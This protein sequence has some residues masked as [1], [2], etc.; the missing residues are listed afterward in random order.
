[1]RDAGGDGDRGPAARDE[2]PDRDE[3]T[4]TLVELPL[5][6]GDPTACLFA[7]QHPAA[8]T[9]VMTD[10]VADVVTC[11]CSQRCR[12]YDERHGEVTSGCNDTGRDDGCLARHQRQDRVDEGEHHKDDV[13]PAGGLS[14]EVSELVE[15]RCASACHH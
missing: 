2:P 4:A 11:E 6:P 14:N 5:G 7:A 9:E 1:M 8:R 3:L 13:R 15:H 10:A 12:G